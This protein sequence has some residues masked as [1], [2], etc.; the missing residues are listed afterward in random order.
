MWSAACQK[1]FDRFREI[2]Q[3][4]LL[5]THYNPKLKILVSADASML[6]LGARIAHIFP[7]GTV[8]AIC[9]VSRS[10]TAAESKY[11][12]IE[13]EGLAL[14]FAVTKFHRML[15]GRHFIL[16]TD[17][18]PLLTIFGSKKGIPIYT[19]NRLQRWALTLLLYDFDIR[20]VSTE[21]F[22]HADILSCLI[23]RNIQPQEEFVIATMELEQLVKNV[24]SEALT[25]LP[26]SFQQIVAATA[27]DD[28]LRQVIQF[29]KNGWPSKK[30]ESADSQLL[31]FYQRR[32]ALSVVEGCIMYGERVVVPQVFRKQVL[33]QLH[34]G[35]PG[36][37]RMRSIARQYVYWPNIDS[38]VIR[39]VSVCTDCASV[40]KTD[41][42][43]NLSSWL[44]P[45]KPWQR[46]HLDYAGSMAGQY[47]LILV[48][49]FSKWPE[50]IR[51]KD[52][53]TCFV[54]FLRGSEHQKR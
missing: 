33:R 12:Q 34:K 31:Q 45:E 23:N 10:L 6:G 2:L 53:T 42:K 30:I 50:V 39:A 7:D 43:T 18:K 26:L 21:N 19:A 4:P 52:I 1:S 5:L 11:S 35:H 15:F 3:S 20:H 16:E 13:K 54:V 48:D 28:S 25:A 41:R 32:D 14:I 49:A 47:Y 27:A 22:G 37:E 51:T 8:R 36:V 40:A 17:H 38:D 29:I 9:H 24:A 46:V 44:A